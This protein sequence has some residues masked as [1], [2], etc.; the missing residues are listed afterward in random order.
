MNIV[1]FLSEL[2]QLDIQISLN[3]DKLKI[4]APQGA[5]TK[6]IKIQL[7]DRKQDIIDFFSGAQK[8]DE[9][10]KIVRIESPVEIPLSFGQQR[11][12]FF[13]EANP[14]TV[15]NNMSA[16]IRLKG[17]LNTDII[18]NVFEA[19]VQ[20]H[21]S[22]RTTFY[23]DEEGVPFQQVS[24]SLGFS[25]EFLTIEGESAYQEQ[26][27]EKLL[28]QEVKQPFDL[29]NGPLLRAKLIAL[30]I[31]ATN[32]CQEH[33]LIIG[34]H[35]IISDGLSV[36]IL[37]REIAMLYWAF[38][39]N[40][41]SP[42]PPLEIQYP[43]FS[44]WQRQYLEGEGL[45]KQLGYWEKKLSNAP[46]LSTF[47]S[48]MTRPPVQTS[49]GATQRVEF[50]EGFGRRLSDFAN[51]NG[52]TP[53]IVLLAAWKMLL[54]RYSQQEDLCVGIPTSGRGQ[55]A[56][57]PI[58][59][60]FVN[61]MVMRTDISEN[62]TIADVL[63]RVKQTVLD[64]L[65]NDD[66]PIEMAVE[67]LKL[68]RNPSYTPLVQ[69]AFQLMAD[70]RSQADNTAA[71]A[72]AGEVTV[73][74]LKKESVS[75]KF[76]I[77]LSM[78]HSDQL[79]RGDLEYNTDLYKPDTINRISE[80]FKQLA[81][82]LLVGDL[83]I[84]LNTLSVVSNDALV[85]EVLGDTAGSY[86][87][88]LPLTA[89]QSD[90]FMDNLVNPTSFQSSHGWQIHIHRPLD[91]ALWQS[92]LQALS[93]HS[94]IL[95]AK[96][97]ATEA[98]Y[99]DMGYLAI[100]KEKDIH[101][102]F[103]DHS[104]D[105][106]SEEELS[107]WITKTIYRPY[108]IQNDELI[109]Y[110]LVKLKED[111]FVAITAVHHAIL[112]GAGLNSLWVQI[113]DR[114]AAIK[115]GEHYHFAD[116]NVADFVAENRSSFDT[117]EHRLFWR[118]QLASVEP[119]DYTVPAPIPAPAHFVTR[120]SYLDTEH[121][122][123]VKKYC[124]KQRIT[125][126]L[127]FKCLFGLVIDNY[128]R[129]DED[130]SIQETM[131][132][133]T[134]ATAETLGCCIQEIPFVFKRDILHSNKTFSD[135]LI[136]ARAYQKTIKNHRKVSIGVQAEMSPKGRVGFMFNFY[137]FLAHT[138]FLG[139]TFNPEGTPSD[140]ANNVQF[141]VTEVAG[142]LKLN[143]FFHQH[144]F[145]DFSML[146]RI[147]ALSEQIVDAQV[148]QLNDLQYVTDQ[149][150]QT[151]LLSTW[152]DT[153]QPFDLT[154]CLHQRFEQQVSL[155]PDR[156]AAVDDNVTLTYQQLNQ[157][158]N[159]LANYLVEKGVGRNDLVGLCAD[160]SVG[161]LI[162]IIGILKAG[163]AYVPMDPKYP[164][165][166][167]TYMQENSAVTVLLSQK[168]L[169]EKVV[170]AKNAHVFY[171]DADWHS[172]E[173]YS[174]ENLSVTV[175]PNDRAYMIYTSGST[176]LPKGAII[177]H[178][179]AVNHIE[180]ERVDLEFPEAFSFLQTAPSSSDISVW[181]FLGPVIC[182]GKT[183]VLDDVTNAKKLFDLVKLHD[184]DVVELVPVALQLLMDHVRTL[185]DIERGLPQL[186]W[187]MATGE[188]VSVDLVNDWLALYPNIPVVNAY[189]PTEAADDVIQCNIKEP[190]EAG[191]RS[192]PIG[193]P[194]AN[195][196]V[197]VVDD[198]L[199]LVPAGIPGEICIS[200]VGVGEGYWQNPEK[201]EE[202]FV[203]NPFEGA[204]DE[205]VGSTMYRT[206]DLGRWLADG[207]IEYLDRVDNQVKIRGFRIELGEVEAAVAGAQGVREGAVIVKKDM[208]GGAALVAFVIA[209]DR[210]GF[211]I[212]SVRTE[213]RGKLP[214]F[215]VPAA[216]E[217]L[218]ELPTTPAGK[219]DKKALEK[220]VISVTDEGEYC[221]PESIE[222]EKVAQIWQEVM[223]RE[224]ISVQS[225]FFDLGGHSLLA[226][227]IV[228]RASQVFE[229]HLTVRALFEF[230]TVQDLA[231]NIVGLLAGGERKE[232]ITALSRD[233]I[234]NKDIRVPLSF[235]QQRL[236]LLDKIDEGSTAYNVPLA[237]RIKGNLDVGQLGTTLT[238]LIQRHEGLRTVFKEDDDGAY[239]WIV[240]ID[241]FSLARSVVVNE[242]AI[243]NAVANEILQPFDLENGPLIR[244]S[245]ITVGD[246]DDSDYVLVIVAHHIVTDGW[247]MNI[248]GQELATL[249]V[250]SNMGLENPLDEPQLQYIDYSLW[251]RDRL[252]GEAFDKHLSYWENTLE[253]LPNL[254]LPTDFQ[255][256][257][258][259]TYAGASVKFE[260]PQDV[261][262]QLE[263][264]AHSN[265]GTLFNALMAAFGVLLSRYTGQNDF[266]IG[267]PVAGRDHPDLEKIV[268]F[269][270]N[271]LVVRLR[272][273]SVDRFDTLVKAVNESV[274]GG[275][276]HQEI[277]FEQ[278]VDAVD[279][280]RDMSR[281]PLFQ[282]M[283]VYQNMDVDQQQMAENATQA[284][285]ISL[286]PVT[287][288]VETAKFD[289]T[290]FV[291]EAT[292]GLSASLQY[293]AD[294][295]E[296]ETI[297][298][299]A[300]HFVS[301]CQRLVNSPDALLADINIL[302]ESEIDVQLHQWNKTQVDYDKTLTVHQ[303]I[304]AQT[305][306]TPN[307]IAVEFGNEKQ[308]YQELDVASNL[309]ASHLISLGVQPGDCVG[310]CFDRSLHIM[311]SILGALKAGATYVP[312]DASY[313]EGRIRYIIEDASIRWVLTR[314]GIQNSLPQGDWLYVDV[315]KELNA[316]D[317]FDE[318]KQGQ[319]NASI[320]VE[321]DAERL[322]YLIYTS[323]ST[324][325][326]KGT[327]AYHR[328]EVNLL[329]WYARDFSLTV[330][331]NLMLMSALG[332][333]LT[334]KN[335]FAPL[336]AGATLV[337]PS[338][339]E[340]DPEILSS[341]IEKHNVTWINCA[342]SAFYGLQ[343]D[344]ESWSKIKSLRHVFLGGEPI[345]QPR[346]D[347]WLRETDCQ[348]INSYGPTE[349][350][351]IAAWHCVDVE[352]DLSGTTLPIGRPND[353]VQL[354]ILG[355]NDELLPIGAIGELCIGGD[356]V[357]PGYLNN[358][359]LTGEVFITHPFNGGSSKIYRTGDLARYRRDGKVE[360]LG[361]RDHQIK[362]R[363]FRIEVGEIQ[364]VINEQS[365]V[366]DSLV[367]T[368]S[369]STGEQLV[370]WVVVS[371]VE[372]LNEQQRE[373]VQAV[374]KLSVGNLL[375]AHM[376]PA[377][378]VLVSN[379]SLTPNGKVDRK[380]LP[381]PSF[382]SSG[383]V[384]SARSDQ[385]A[386][387][388]LLWQDVLGLSEIGVTQNFFELGGHSLLATKVIAR[389]AKDLNVKMSVRS[390]FENPTIEQ[391]ASKIS[392]ASSVIEH[393]LSVVNRD[394]RI[395]LSFAQ[396]RL[397]LLDKIEPGSV[398][399]NMP[400]A[401]RIQGEFNLDALKAAYRDLVARHES[402]RTVF[403]EDE[404]GAHQTFLSS[405][406][407]DVVESDISQSGFDQS[408]SDQDVLI[409][410]ALSQ[411]IVRLVAIEIMKPFNLTYGP[412][413]R[414][415][416]L[417]IAPNDV[418][419]TIVVH[420]IVTDGWSM[421]IL[422][423]ELV[424]LYLRHAGEIAPALK[425]LTYQ[426]A[427]FASWQRDVLTDSALFNK[428]AYWNAQLSD[429]EPLAL[430]TDKTR[431]SI[432]TYAGASIPF[433]VSDTVKQGLER[434]A[435]K[436]GGTL[437]NSLLA[438]FS[439]VLHRYSGQHDF[440]IGTP[441]AGR[442]NS[443]LEK[444][445]GFFVNTL[446]LRMNVNPELSFSEL[447]QQVKQTA[448]LGYE[449]QDVPFE[450][451][452]QEVDPS[453][454]MSRS[455]L[456]QVMLSYQNMPVES[457]G[458]NSNQ[459]MSI[460]PV[461][462]SVETAKYELTLNF[463]EPAA[464]STDGLQASL[465]YNTDLFAEVTAQKLV[466]HFL[467]LCD[468]IV[469]VEGVPSP[470]YTI[471][472][473]NDEEKQRQLV[474]WN[475]TQVD[476]QQDITIDSLFSLQAEKTPNA[477]AVVCG[478]NSLSYAALS[479][480]ANQL[481]RYLQSQGIVAG[482]VVGLCYDRALELP[483]C[484]LGILLAGATYVPLDASYPA[485][486]LAYIMD[487]AGI[488]TVVTRS[489]LL[490]EDNHRNLICF[491]NQEQRIRDFSVD[492]IQSDQDSNRLLYMI[493]TSG[494]T[495]RPKGTGATHY[496]E[497]NLLNWYCREFSM[498]EQDNV[499]LMSA[500]GFDLTQKNIFAP[501]ISG[502]TLVIPD[503]QEYDPARFLSIIESE[504][505]SWINCA[506][507][508][509]YPLQDDS[510]DWRKLQSLKYLFLGGE[511][512]N[513]QRLQG[514]L[515]S[516]TQPLD[517]PCELIN[518]Y[519]PTECADIA[520]WHRIDL[521][522]DI[523][524]VNLPI[525]RPND[526]VKL[527][528][529]GQHQELLPIG[530]IGELYIGGDSVGPGYL[531]DAEMTASAFFLNPFVSNKD[532][533]DKQ[534]RMYKTGDLARY[535]ADGKVEY[536]GRID[537][538]VKLRGYRI[539]T[540]EIQSVINE[541]ENIT[542]SLVAVSNSEVTGDSLVAWVV[543]S[544]ALLENDTEG[545]TKNVG[546]Q[547]AKLLP[548]FMVPQHF[549]LLS[550]FP[551]TPNG[552]VDRKA[553]PKPIE[554]GSVELVPAENATQAMLVDIWQS[555]LGVSAIGIK[556]DFFQLGGHSL[557]AT[558]VVARVS[559]QTSR[560][561]SVRML[562]E[563]PTIE[564][565]AEK[566]DIAEAEDSSRPEVLRLNKQDNIPLSFGQK[567]L[568]Y[569]EQMNPGSSANNMP[570]AV[571]VKGAF[572][573]T[574]L[575]KAYAELL[576][577]HESLRT[578]F[579]A[580][581]EGVPSQRIH[582]KFD[583]PLSLL[584]FVHDSD[585]EGKALAYA[586]N[587]RATGFDL[588][589]GPL[590]RGTLLIIKDEKGNEDSILTFCLHHII[591]DGVSM[592][593]LLRELTTLYVAFSNKMPSPLPE[594]SLQYADFAQWQQ[595][596]L[597]DDA[598]EGQL[599]HWQ[600]HLQNAPALLTLPTDRPRPSV[601]TTNGNVKG[602]QFS[603]EFNQ[604][605]TQFAREQGV[606]PFMVMLLSWKL[607]LSKYAQQDSV[608]VGI[609]TAGRPQQS[610]ENI[611]GFFINSMV[612]NTE[613]PSSLSVTEA[614]QRVRES[615]LGG[616]ANADVPV[617]MVLDRLQVERNPSYTPLA[618]VAFQ[619]NTV[620][621]IAPD[622]Q[623]LA[624]EFGGLSVEPLSL[625][626]VS[627]KFDMT[628][629]LSQSVEQLSGDLEFN[630][631][632]FDENTMDKLI[633]HYMH[634]SEAIVNNPAQRVA[635]VELCT[636]SELMHALNISVSQYTDVLPLSAMQYDMFMD[637]LVNPSTLQSSHGWALHVHN[638]ID[639]ALWQRCLQQFSDNAPILR[640]QFVSAKPAYLDVGYLAIRKQHVI[641]Y[642]FMDVS[643][644]GYSSADIKHITDKII[645]RPYDILKDEFVRFITI[646]VADKHYVLVAAVHHAIQDGAALNALWE[647]VT[648][649]YTTLLKDPQAEI[650]FND[651]NF[652][653]FVAVDR[654]VMD[655]SSVL[656]FWKDK[657]AAVEPLDFT[658]P[659]PI[660]E[661]AAYR[662]QEFYLDKTHWAEVK[663]YC[664]KQRITPAL[665]FKVLYGLMINTYCRPDSDF[666]IQE[667]MAG[668]GKGHYTSQGCYIQEIPF[669]FGK[670]DFSS[671]N[672]IASI[673]NVARQFQKE[674]KRYRLISIGEQIA[675]S[676]RGRIGFMYNYYHFL[677]DSEFLGEVI[678][679]QGTPS[680]PAENIQ[681]VV[682]EVRG[683][684]KIT[685][686]YH[687][688][689]FEDFGLVDR[690]V[691]LSRQIVLGDA[692]TL[693]DL[694][695][696]TE[697]EEITT[698]LTD[699]NTTAEDFDLSLC[700]H[701]RFERQV[702]QTPESIAVIDDNVQYSYREL[703]QRANQ[704]ARY[705]VGANS[706]VGDL[707]G[708][709]AERSA[710]FL[711][712]ILGIQKAGGAYV[713]MDPK[714]PQ[715]RITYMRDNSEVEIVLSQQHLSDKVE[716]DGSARIVYLDTDWQKINN[717]ASDNLNIDIPTDSRAYM[718]YTSGSTGKPKG[719]I[720][721]HDGAVNHIEAERKVLGFEGA[722][723]FL[724]TA[725]SSSDI[726]VWQFLGPVICG[727]KTVVLDDVTHAE[728]MFALVKEHQLEVV[729]LVPVALQ[730]LMEYVRQLP[731]VDRELPNLRWMMATGEAVSVELVN[732]WL[733]LYPE[734]PV[735]NAYGPTEAADDVIQCA[736]ET[737]LPVGQRSVPIG[738]PLANL[739]V[740]VLDDELRLVPAGV[741]GEICI[742]GV[743]VGE[744][745]WNNVEK[746]NEV[747]VNNPYSKVD[748]LH[749]PLSKIQGD[750]IYR[751]G[752][753]GRWLVDG[754]VEYLDRVDNQVK[755]RGFRIELGEV[756]AAVSALPAV[757]EAV[758]IVRDDMPGGTALAAY[759]VA[760]NVAG[761]KVSPVDTFDVAAA[762]AT[763]RE[764]LPD[765]MVPT[766]LMAME[767]LPLT[768]A[769]KVDRK[770]LPKPQLMV[771]A[772]GEYVAPRTDM[773]SALVEMWEALLP[774]EQ[775]GV[776]DNFFDIGGHSLI[777]VRLMARVS[778]EFSVSLQIVEL[779][780]AP[781][782]E[783][784]CETIKRSEGDTEWTPLVALRKVKE[785]T[786]TENEVT[787][788]FFIHPVGGDVLCYTDLVACLPS[789]I[790]VYGLQAR[791]F[792]QGADVFAS[793][794]EM[795]DC[796]V[797][798]IQAQ[799][800]AGVYRIAA[801]SLGGVIAIR[802]A[803]KLN[804]MG[805]CV[806]CIMMFDTFT[807]LAM[808]S[809]Q[810]SNVQ[811][812]ESAIGQPLPKNVRHLAESGDDQW[813]ETLYK[814]AKA[815]RMLPD[816]LTLAQIQSIYNVAITNHRLVSQAELGDAD[817][818][819]R[820]CIAHYAAS[821]RVS[822]ESSQTDWKAKGYQ[823]NYIDVP[824][825][826][827]SMIRGE[828]AVSL[829]KMI[830]GD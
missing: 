86:E 553:L 625:G 711:V 427:D 442:E 784:L 416:V 78:T 38:N 21:E 426:Y 179:G 168:H 59:G 375:P 586:A 16:G 710:D 515:S 271:T 617:D 258:V 516:S 238:T 402:L 320:L 216:I 360:Y 46:M 619:L 325:R 805:G 5:L 789:N 92:S 705:L 323:G 452:V 52:V 58:I 169:A 730:L 496:A 186:R 447:V 810:L 820:Y 657:L 65:D 737:P 478:E 791:G 340:Y 757:R 612:L 215:M 103:I 306:K 677:A 399:Y 93:D 744:G 349:C 121:W 191:Q 301:L 520:A 672:D 449:H 51:Q 383:E 425:P 800:P 396:Q 601:Q 507:S 310:F 745:Y 207:S 596:Y 80:Q 786:D 781:T 56:L 295:F 171:L 163:G 689:V 298:G 813:L 387:L 665:Y 510:D 799:H 479:G 95:R 667:T 294:L 227:K 63:E 134:S 718:I 261:R 702:L 691:S 613:L 709:C 450:Q 116:D 380:A 574:V 528:V 566:V 265:G 725:P 400:L 561:V 283:L 172:I 666:V 149:N 642:E 662:S 36:A 708:L 713:P 240:G 170:A 779:L 18:Q 152:N 505:V 717:F 275:Y 602:L 815:A 403:K 249:Y 540:G 373:D 315:E 288:D 81:E 504:Q 12:W 344:P 123:G 311:T 151:L 29:N 701:Q 532:E 645:Y 579:S 703:N 385:E 537:H 285:D 153:Q 187:M 72:Q 174:T 202:A 811:V 145:S 414:A 341:L 42:L 98:P 655:T 518:S 370:A 128:C 158:T 777:G 297:E 522:V 828:H 506:P 391:F 545:F 307:N 649:A 214:D 3:G 204:H 304:A 555:V 615:V 293:N 455:P 497:S 632:L 809:D 199:R 62:P 105:N 554:E 801:Q 192:V 75:A 4:K 247:S 222:E 34:M 156:I 535:R 302:D 557:L 287:Y 682:T 643:D 318:A 388:V 319:N 352:S 610:L 197:F 328:S 181:Q 290:L 398:A 25:T 110:Y 201:T 644:K 392:D 303:W 430:P 614:L 521:A 267:S 154:L 673:F 292:E 345:N 420:H 464:G 803:E 404:E 395:A 106:I 570:T 654:S 266:A 64:G 77:T 112:D 637:N 364:S 101:W 183:V 741:P 646:K 556:Q 211:S 366:V 818:Y 808:I 161:F 363:G 33:I 264:I 668:R 578:T 607:L 409:Q 175:A 749:H 729:E 721:R 284:G 474:A 792:V 511:P 126:A 684:L 117:Q 24:D 14:G 27:V 254:N 774:V 740:L 446:A 802:V 124:R 706:R 493:Y 418:V 618:Q 157:K 606:T 804:A 84:P 90:M 225:N 814:T 233:A 487:N 148:E 198:Q 281:S 47:P 468:A 822:G 244:A 357:G 591:S 678:D 656:A 417:H 807:P 37:M 423:Q 331:D 324:G 785:R 683:D 377:A 26:K 108:D 1:D 704:L 286:H 180:A 583:S 250:A 723:S 166:R 722:F 203:V 338:V 563:S 715:D 372:T 533:T 109:S 189:G 482:D 270:V 526:N 140:P 43:D 523:A 630:T 736:I 620:D 129:P 571:R 73:E 236:W 269:F 53:F 68:S 155:T 444:I 147:S 346:I 397:W 621:T 94:A 465:Q 88:V 796:Y 542:D 746:T 572:D 728:K 102:E 661:P 783:Q 437:F 217:L 182:G 720:V 228:S 472:L 700:L 451:I 681:F 374:L 495:G 685:L 133:R 85:E 560:A 767:Q 712:G 754:T 31:L 83:S 125:P 343:D 441:V 675:L 260:L 634:L 524:A 367:A 206:G 616:F 707:V 546:R 790:P 461:E 70:T 321:P 212:A 279:P 549:V 788:I 142:E 670:D 376:I 735:V 609:P 699:W 71:P 434:L 438:A 753:L 235:A 476:Y 541:Q 256:P 243:R 751:T 787:P 350:T 342:P 111:H 389:V 66:I 558:Q 276:E 115:N 237:M 143:L 35:H 317:L 686:L 490:P 386:R 327:G 69:I 573:I 440:C 407:F 257:S 647:Q 195:L 628:L 299:L 738:K 401:I 589:E 517:E 177:R 594:L 289:L 139:Q 663:Q 798:A 369:S 76:D 688:H 454:D 405:D 30:P 60:F 671:S 384:I 776:T 508:A 87:T 23:V 488:T 246:E 194:L 550:E 694:Q 752:D 793:F 448:L 812:I 565:F 469:A 585:G 176:G 255:R 184:L 525:G 600:K 727:G 743:G 652:A 268:G 348:L 509:F 309:V 32:E 107:E 470:I 241:G 486:R 475:Q 2:R 412:L 502:A 368:H 436:E 54:S 552:K 695:Y 463:N 144:L 664:R 79:V 598:L 821:D 393:P 208:P 492:P 529:L 795:I 305:E 251:Q 750:I 351:D 40:M 433:V 827:E 443:D 494:S 768:P 411:E 462:F 697:E 421:N 611:I 530:A 693:G 769:G 17:P 739:S 410:S 830:A 568:W 378:W 445:V 113:T 164:Q 501:L 826:H 190:I 624:A 674:I 680:D 22:L 232:I 242:G 471:D 477:V 775:V 296:R 581:G 816:D 7:K 353:N 132:G 382:A 483:E 687:P 669:V 89:M 690:V 770:A 48:D 185:P 766:A 120:E 626:G 127:Y 10:K 118:D 764:N 413:T 329:A 676:P 8:Q 135:V 576:R 595:S 679:A 825:D 406:T 277:P 512:I 622:Q 658:V 419:L 50:P 167:L 74:A 635:N 335:L 221:P 220:R 354:Y 173:Q 747:F 548:S 562:F 278:I 196:N 280:T 763:L 44:I 719:A 503:V 641:N 100:A 466:K 734:V 817:L 41:A 714:Y 312:L 499:L 762:R 274:V 57:E 262:D 659:A 330:D 259:Q 650:T 806:E 210:D 467:Q 205:V 219:V 608:S 755:V 633:H 640:S 245:L 99:L 150:E 458:G 765:Y 334:Q 536:L 756:E 780:N 432:Q 339:Q 408:V 819:N 485:E 527:Y 580:D 272:L 514:W 651:E 223:G 230:P 28:A 636:Q 91:V 362:L 137:Q 742:S 67:R 489:D 136:S 13:E 119:L 45:E 424:S 760:E 696:V 355:S 567:R 97:V 229:V 11:L 273:E 347:S 422:G 782:I 731:E 82:Y 604:K 726:S 538:Q 823:F 20:R 146:Q 6:E 778:Q 291:S 337:I 326:P 213:L 627:A 733:A 114:Y 218:D 234:A 252:D 358:A 131:G 333:D 531:G 498:T 313:P 797:D 314:A 371:G 692:E 162:G 547:I 513:L 460:K 660:P 104:D 653:E 316:S 623:S 724:Q 599:A 159:Q 593:I 551:L 9:S 481:A 597:T 575:Q 491:D 19:L 231:A 480:R 263:S 435:R 138:E 631:D 122:A 534:E 824:G 758:V 564:L 716:S 379:F 61:S 648:D 55:P 759:I 282:T 456:F 829:A 332:F 226:T 453:R 605:L 209:A 457:E 415:S 178:D 748:Y 130:F 592:A 428:L 300:H 539:E 500:I 569:F 639:E 584:S 394:Q 588:E 473:L 381:L 794:D 308:T 761:Q 431:P 336:V 544:Q 629:S 582:Q 559:K 771:L 772:G 638:E 519:G 160:R 773:E 603:P 732:A 439:I 429:V 590:V 224:K 141:V 188:A 49:N 239:Q 248:L 322:L 577:R 484:I 361:R 587:D 193:K 15:A 698:L 365:S 356:S 543:V 459:M 165:D 200:G 390:L 359:E 39:S 253:E 96:F